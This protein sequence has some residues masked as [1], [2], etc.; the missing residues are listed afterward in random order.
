MFAWFTHPRLLSCLV[1]LC[2][3][4]SFRCT[5]CD[6]KKLVRESKV[7]E[8]FVEKGMRNGETVVFRGEADQV[9][10]VEPGNLVVRLV[11]K[12]HPVFKREGPHLFVK[13]VSE[14]FERR[15][16][17]PACARRDRERKMESLS[18]VLCRRFR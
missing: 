16:A 17:V 4:A 3:V 8:V 1:P 6:G 2:G 10:D 12:P 7:F 9:P 18:L 13:K 15:A 11:Q 14:R 5:T